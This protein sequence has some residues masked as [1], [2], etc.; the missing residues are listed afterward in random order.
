MPISEFLWSEDRVDH[1]ARHG[2]RP[3]EFEKVCFG[4]PLVLR[5]KATGPKPVYYLLGETEARRLLFCV[6]IE[7]P[8]AGPTLWPRAR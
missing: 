3:E 2:V 6:A 1:I 8:A 4:A 5:T 7:S